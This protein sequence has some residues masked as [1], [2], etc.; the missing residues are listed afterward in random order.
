MLLDRT[1]AGAPPSR[2]GRA[3]TGRTD[4]AE[5]PRPEWYRYRIRIPQ[6]SQRHPREGVVLNDVHHVAHVPTARRILEDK[7]VRAALVYDKSRL[8]R[9]RTCV[10]WASANT[11]APGS[12]Y[13]NVQFTFDW[14]DILRDRQIYWVEAIDYNP[15]AYRF[16]LTDGVLDR[17]VSSKVVAY[18]PAVDKG[19]LREREGVWYFN[20]EYNSEFMIDGDL[21]LRRCKRVSFVRHRREICSLHGSSCTDRTASEFETGGRFLAHMLGDGLHGLDHAFRRP[22]SMRS[23][24]P[25]TDAVDVGVGGILKVLRD[26]PVLFAGGIRRPRSAQ[27]AVLGALALYGA[28]REAEARKSASM[29]ASVDVFDDALEAIVNEHFGI[30][31]WKRF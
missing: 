3:A 10:A 6:S 28:D 19:P 5:E 30:T 25:L 1:G 16:L 11:W 21:P 7:R 14:S 22:A 20:G 8:N 12:I 13:G 23:R 9:S 2:R 29:L 17:E 18:D 27:A 26:N 4:P 15:P 31:G 24:L